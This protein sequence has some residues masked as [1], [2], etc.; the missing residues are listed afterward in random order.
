MVAADMALL[1]CAPLVCVKGEIRVITE[2]SVFVCL[3]FVHA[4]PRFLNILFLC[5]NWGFLSWCG[6]L[7]GV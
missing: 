1:Q 7:E 4:R 2:E 5:M 3:C 6:E